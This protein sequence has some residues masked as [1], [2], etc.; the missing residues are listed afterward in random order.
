MKGRLK[1]SEDKEKKVGKEVVAECGRCEREPG[2]TNVRDEICKVKRKM[3]TAKS[4][5]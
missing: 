1:I 2:A 5:I 4:R 3:V